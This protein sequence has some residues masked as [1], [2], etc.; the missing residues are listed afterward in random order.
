MNRFCHLIDT[1]NF[2]L[3]KYYLLQADHYKYYI[4]DF[5]GTT[6]KFLEMNCQQAKQAFIEFRP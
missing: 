2:R 6:Y 4:A 3:K 1:K 5:K